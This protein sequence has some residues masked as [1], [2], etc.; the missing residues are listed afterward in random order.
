MSVLF[1]R[2]RLP[3]AAFFPAQ[4]VAVMYLDL[5]FFPIIEMYF[6]SIWTWTAPSPGVHSAHRGGHGGVA[7]DP[8]DGR[9][10]Q[11]LPGDG[12]GAHVAIG[13]FAGHVQY[14]QPDV[15]RGPGIA[16]EPHRRV[17]LLQFPRR[18]V[19]AFAQNGAYALLTRLREK[20][21]HYMDFLSIFSVL[22]MATGDIISPQKTSFS[23]FDFSSNLPYIVAALH[24]SEA[25]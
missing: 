10:R 18:R 19:Q 21:N 3:P 1:V 23:L 7:D 14:S 4:I 6:S 20:N 11:S 24:L 16:A 9:L 2:A 13:A 15:R 8:A 22:A 17:Q 25:Q 12:V 5:C